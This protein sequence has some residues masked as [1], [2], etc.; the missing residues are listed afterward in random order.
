MFVLLSFSRRKLRRSSAAEQ[1]TACWSPPTRH[2][3]ECTHRYAMSQRRN[4]EFLD[5][6]I[7]RE[8]IYWPLEWPGVKCR[9]CRCFGSWRCCWS[10]SVGGA[11][12]EGRCVVISSHQEDVHSIRRRAA[13]WS[14]EGWWREDGWSQP[15]WTVIPD[16]VLISARVH[17][18]PCTHDM[19]LGM[20]LDMWN[21]FVCKHLQV[22]HNRAELSGVLRDG[23]SS[24]LVKL[25]P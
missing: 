10:W 6:L 18:L 19:G 1:A 22:G 11:G 17:G 14:R 8:H 7:V 9:F 13:P 20:V 15:E 5:S 16:C 12:G 25:L 24:R 3:V 21:G 4:L 2:R 23:R